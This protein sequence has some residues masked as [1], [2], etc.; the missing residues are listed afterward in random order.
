MMLI[1][2]DIM[3]NAPKVTLTNIVKR[4]Y[5]LGSENL[6]NTVARSRGTY[7]S[8]TL[9]R[10]KQ[11]IENFYEFICQRKAGGLE[12]WSDWHRLHTQPTAATA[13]S[14][15]K[16]DGTG[17]MIIETVVRSVSREMPC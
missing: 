6:F 17:K 4:Q 2:L 16:H 5:L 3:K 15:E 9:T 10:R 14:Q 1:M 13:L 7:Y 11:F 12:R 8:S